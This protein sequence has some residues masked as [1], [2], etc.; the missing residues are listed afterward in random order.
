MRVTSTTDRRRPQPTTPLV[1]RRRLEVAAEPRG[2]RP[3]RVA[4]VAPPWYSV[5]PQGYGGIEA[6]VAELAD[7]LVGRGHDVVLIAAGETDTTARAVATYDTVQAERMGESVVEVAHAAEAGRLLQQ[8]RPDVVHDH[9]LA[10]PLLATGRSAPTVVTAHGPASGDFHRLYSALGRAV[11]LVAISEA[12][13]RAAPDL[14]WRGMVHNA[15]SVDRFRFRADKEDYALFL[16]RANP[17]KGLRLAIDAARAAGRRLVLALKR[18]EAHEEDYFEAEV[19]PHLGPDVEYV[20]EATGQEKLALLAGA[21]C[22]L[23]PVQWEEPFGMVAI[24]AMASG[25]PVV[26][27]PRGALP[28]VVRHGVT[29]FLVADDEGFAAAIESTGQLDPRACRAH[30]RAAFSARAMADGYERVYRAALASTRTR[31][32]ARLVT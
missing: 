11:R 19:R 29:G 2:S 32:V 3:L 25:T 27:C 16:G 8:L 14:L 1:R 4:L 13:R 31:R 22:L 20:G 15:V 26:A 12:Q 5:P 30:V 9:A 18:L 23:A 21:R 17:D 10:G 28:E 24:E 6:V 7:E